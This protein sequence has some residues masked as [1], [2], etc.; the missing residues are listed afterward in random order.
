M[1]IVIVVMLLAST[2]SCKMEY[3][4]KEVEVELAEPKTVTKIDQDRYPE[5]L[6]KVFEAHGGLAN[7][8][9]KKTLVFKQGEELH[10]LDLKT[11]MDRVDGPAYSLGY[12]G[13]KVW[14]VNE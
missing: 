10:T 4:T 12:D 6:I 9:N 8:K 13:D 1:K 14:L 3:K 2:L 7:W 11:R 5:A